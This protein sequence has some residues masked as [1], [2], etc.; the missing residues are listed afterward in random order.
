MLKILHVTSEAVPYSKTGG[1]ADVS[2]S[3]PE[4]LAALGHQVSIV[5]PLYSTVDRVAHDIAF[6]GRVIEVTLGGRL[7]RF[8]VFKALTPEGVSVYL[9]ENHGFFGRPEIYGTRDGAYDDNHLRYGFF[10]SAAF[11]L[12]SVMGLEPDVIHCHD[13]QT[14]LVPLFNK[15]RHFNHYK[16]VMTVHNMG[17][18][19]AFPGFVMQ[20]TGIPWEVYNPEGVEY[21]GQ[22]SFL[23][24]GLVFAD[25]ATTVSPRYAE[26]VLRPEFGYGMDG[27]LRSLGSRFSG[28][29]NGVD[30]SRWSP[31][32]D[33]LLPA[34][35]SADD[36]SGKTL[37][38]AALLS[39]F[40]LT[41][42]GGPLFGVIG[43][44]AYQKG[45]DLLAEIIPRIV[46]LGGMLVVLGTGER[47][48]EDMLTSSAAGF[49]GSVSV[50]LAYS[51]ELAH[52]IEAGS[53]FFLMPSRY[54]PCGLNQL[55]SLKY[56]TI[57]VV[58]AVGG[59]ENTVI[60]VDADIEHGT[61]IKFK[62]FDGAEFSE[63]VRRACALYGDKARLDSVRARGMAQDFSWSVSARKYAELYKSLL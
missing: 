61:G 2:F 17:Y 7:E 47:A 41:D 18:Q 29:L 36:M 12:I 24:A 27:V 45:Y 8:G 62:R 56:G 23:K 33:V 55:Y 4:A 44:L 38:R 53:D 57:P 52:L 63:A 6:T 50:K 1:L 20:E 10:S 60:D 37:N 39:S 42:S 3:L 48:V 58:H 31:D 19:G 32:C 25:R 46:S 26:E 35:Y 5:T 59:L 15:V 11:E 51:E 14:G 30:Y 43:R 40:D 54:E 28:I 21:W 16:T 49:R 13:W 22:V 9:L 34:C